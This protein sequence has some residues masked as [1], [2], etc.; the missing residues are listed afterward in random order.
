MIKKFLFLTILLGFFVIYI[1]INQKTKEPHVYLSPQD[2]ILKEKIIPQQNEGL[3]VISFINQEL[4]KIKSIYCPK[5]NIAFKQGNGPKFRVNG[6]LAAEKT[7]NFRLIVTHRLTGKEM[8]LGSNDRLFWFWNKRMKPPYLHFSTHE[9]LNKTN[10]KAVLNPLWLM[11]SF[12]IFPIEFAEAEISKHKKYWFVKNK[13][14]SNLGDEVTYV[15]L[16][17]PEYKR[18]IGRYLYN[19]KEE[20]FASAEYQEFYGCLPTIATFIWYDEQIS[21][22]IN[23]QE[24]KINEGIDQKYWS[25]PSYENPI[26]IGE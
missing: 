14:A 4:G 26:N 12:G 5:T 11:E 25:M 15:T 7:K 6:E 23:L 19:K 24:F 17:D 3:K 13:K 16:I 8:D 20:L 18:V 10:L 2:Q 21:L 9:N 22:E 1:Q